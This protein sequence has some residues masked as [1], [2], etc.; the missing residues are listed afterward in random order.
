MDHGLAI[1][2]CGGNIVC[3]KNSTCCKDGPNFFVHPFTGEVKD[4][5]LRDT[6]ASPT[7]W[8]V[9]STSSVISSSTTLSSSSTSP[10][11]TSA[12]SSSAPSD[13]TTPMSHSGLSPGASA[14]IGVGAG[15]AVIGLAFL[16][17][18]FLRRRKKTRALQTQ[19]E[20]HD[21]APAHQ[22][23]EGKD[24]SYNSGYHEAPP[25]PL[26]ELDQGRPR[27]EMY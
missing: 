4:S 17:W 27:H 13:T 26:L 19:N 21:I 20:Q 22:Y 16:G 5:S 1:Q 24:G 15:A 2:D 18:L 8:E 11:T 10:T 9:V 23:Q 3:Y 25:P 6:T 14:G 12:A 7:Y